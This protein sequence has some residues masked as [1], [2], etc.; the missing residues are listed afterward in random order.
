MRFF[1]W[2]VLCFLSSM[3]HAVSDLVFEVGAP[4][5]EGSEITI[6]NLPVKKDGN[7]LTALSLT[8]LQ[9]N[10]ITIGNKVHELKLDSIAA[11]QIVPIKINYTDKSIDYNLRVLP[12]DMP[13]Y[14][15]NKKSEIS[16]CILTSF[17]V[18]SL[19]KPSYAVMIDDKGKLLWFMGTQ[20]PYTT[21][22]HPQ[23]WDLSG[24]TLYSYHVQDSPSMTGAWILGDNVVLDA[25]FK[26]IDRVRILETERHPEMSADQHDFVILGDK[27]YLVISYWPE[28]I[29]KPDGTE[30][31]IISAVIQE[32]KDGMVIFDWVSSDYDRLFDICIENC[33]TVWNSYM[34]YIHINSVAVDPTDNNLIV[35]LA[36]PHSVIKLD[37]NSGDI[38][39]VFSGQGDEFNIPSEYQLTRQHDAHIEDGHLVIFDNNYSIISKISSVPN[40]TDEARLLR[41]KL[42]EKNKRVQEV[43]SIPL[44]ATAP[45]M[46]SAQGLG[47]GLWNMGCGSSETCITKIVDETGNDVLSVKVASPYT[48]YRVYFYPE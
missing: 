40:K 32:Q 24:R 14:E 22:F 2:A 33:P 10:I 8:T 7:E 9:P 6:N 26:E 37:R 18:L 47:N 3:C 4:A 5:S 20:D 23:K 11:D 34:D 46:G 35:S 41:F 1:L 48:S 15:F 21:I 36:S 45:Y 19:N 38:I 44:G 42:D 39:W 27:H 16:G 13:S 17:H 29:K 25:N 43:S 12:A 28:N 31:S 30:L